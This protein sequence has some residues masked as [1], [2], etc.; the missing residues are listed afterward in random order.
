MNNY[1][2]SSVKEVVKDVLKF[3]PINNINF[4][5]IHVLHHCD[6]GILILKTVTNIVKIFQH[7]CPSPL[8]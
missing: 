7:S 4:F 8:R 3:M 1:N 5:I 2:A 6:K